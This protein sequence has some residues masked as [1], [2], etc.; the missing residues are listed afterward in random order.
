[1]TAEGGNPI[2][3][4]TH[5][6][7]VMRAGD[8]TGSQAASALELLCRTYIGIRSMPTSGA[9]AGMFTRVWDKF[10]IRLGFCWKLKKYV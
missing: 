6:S 1:M 9:A 10:L 4:S 7:L 8:G 5:W 3:A 2:F